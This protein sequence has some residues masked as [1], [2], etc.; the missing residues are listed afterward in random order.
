MI[1][2]PGHDFPCVDT[3]RCPRTF[4]PL[5]TSLPCRCPFL[6]S[7]M[8]PRFCSG[9]RPN[10]SPFPTQTIESEVV[11]WP[12]VAAST[13]SQP[14]PS[15]AR[16]EAMERQQQELIS[17]LRQREV[18]AQQEARFAEIA[19]H[20]TTQENE[21]R[22]THKGPA[23]SQRGMGRGAPETLSLSHRLAAWR[24]LTSYSSPVRGERYAP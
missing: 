22:A 16:L 23:R 13:A 21:I 4:S 3:S 11:L 10:S 5:L 9:F 2:W 18:E 24:M 12:S 19:R 20:M 1:L 15:Y 7:S 14:R 8:I 17:T 6:M